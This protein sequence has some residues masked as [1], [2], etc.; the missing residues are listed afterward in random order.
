[1][2][3]NA[4][5]A[6]ALALDGG[7][8]AVPAKSEFLP[9]LPVLGSASTLELSLLLFGEA[10][11]GEFGGDVPLGESGPG[12]A[13]REAATG[14]GRFGEHEGELKVPPIICACG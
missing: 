9:P 13:A 6:T 14:V 7:V 11:L 1:M 2:S 3:P 5:L 8:W 10:C 4:V 12:S